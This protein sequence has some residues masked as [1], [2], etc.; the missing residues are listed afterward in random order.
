MRFLVTGASGFI[1]NELV[2]CLI[3]RGHD[4]VAMS[5]KGSPRE[6]QCTHESVEFVKHDLSNPIKDVRTK[7]GELDGIAHLAWH[8]LPNYQ[9]AYHCEQNLQMSYRFLAS[10]VDEGYQ[11][12]FVSGTSLEYGMIN[13]C[14]AETEET[15]PVTAYGM[16]KDGLRRMLEDLKQSK[17]FNLTWGRI[18]YLTGQ[19][20]GGSSL[21]A[22]LAHAVHV[23]E[24]RFL[25]S[26]GE[27]LR[28]Y[29]P[30]ATTAKII[31]SLLESKSDIGPINICS[32]SPVS[33]RSLVERW[34]RE[35][36]AEIELVLGYY[37]YPEYEPM[38]FWGGRE[39]LDTFLEVDFCAD[40]T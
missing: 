38:E 14:I 20:R 30:V 35:N 5:R 32:G 2:Q 7:F 33:V 18:F 34:L 31:A 3:D 19:T 12:I 9:A 26:G 27:Q 21:L 13:G 37:P 15:A 10:M 8:G 24:K 6:L 16:A 40:K 28:D 4:V 11:N 17:F 22:Q 23:G 25:M 36:Q 39:K 1:G 29:L